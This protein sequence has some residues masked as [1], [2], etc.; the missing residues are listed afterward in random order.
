MDLCGNAFMLRGEGKI[1]LEKKTLDL[2]FVAGGPRFEKDTSVTR[3][4]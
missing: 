1:D 2:Q 4:H 3:N